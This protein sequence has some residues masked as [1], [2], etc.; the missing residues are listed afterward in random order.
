MGFVL[1]WFGLKQKKTFIA[2]YNCLLFRT[3]KLFYAKAVRKIGCVLCRCSAFIYTV[4]ED[5]KWGS[6]DC[7]FSIWVTLM[8][9]NA[10]CLR[11]FTWDNQ[12]CRVNDCDT[13]ERQM[14]SILAAV[15]LFHVYQYKR[16]SPLYCGSPSVIQWEILY[17]AVSFLLCYD[18][19]KFAFAIRSPPLGK[20]EWSVACVVPI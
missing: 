2:S 18:C 5:L 14:A 11:N 3:I 6:D 15:T 1:W 17:F 10:E 19:L 8:M 12:T 9:D 16:S 20:C 4:K 7:N 13:V